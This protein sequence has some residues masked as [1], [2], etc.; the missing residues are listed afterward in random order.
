VVV[1]AGRDP[2]AVARDIAEAVAAALARAGVAAR[3]GERA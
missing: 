3:I 2:D 1:D